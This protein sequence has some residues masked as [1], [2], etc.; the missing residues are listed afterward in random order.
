MPGEETSMI[1]DVDSDADKAAVLA[2]ET[3]LYRAMI[4]TDLAAL[5]GILSADLVYIHSTAVA[6]G[7]DLYLKR[8]SERRYD[9]RSIASRDVTV[10]IRQDLAVMYGTLDMD[11]A[12][13]GGPPVMMHLLFTL[14]WTRQDGAWKLSL[15]QST[16]IPS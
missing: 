11:V 5:S 2:A 12:T 10:R 1:E 14:V 9:Y 7:R 13:A 4:D 16:N 8:V 6:E 15:R 3:A